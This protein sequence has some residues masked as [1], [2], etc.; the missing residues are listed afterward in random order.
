M[1]NTKC[2]CQKNGHSRKSLSGMTPLY[3]IGGFTLIELLMVVLII[4][5]L[6]AVA[7]PQYQKAVEKSKAIQGMALVKSLAQ[8]AQ[9]YYLANGTYAT[10]TDQLDVSLS[11][12][13]KEEF[14]CNDIYHKCNKKEWG[15]DVYQNVLD[16][17]AIIGWRTS[18]KYKGGGFIIYLND[19]RNQ[20]NT[21]YCYERIAGPNAI[22]TKGSYC[23]KLFNGKY[24]SHTGNAYQ[25]T[26]P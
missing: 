17:H 3:N 9:A 23:P 19:G 6:A 16:E 15:V 1:E 8:A 5:I 26:L 7:V 18:G 20:R 2:H 21:L 22:E 25:Y 12:A 10:S 11:D 13:Q 4:G 24:L 14:Y